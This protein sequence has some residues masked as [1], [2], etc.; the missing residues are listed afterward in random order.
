MTAT[1]TRKKPA[2]AKP[3]R[4]KVKASDE[5]IIKQY[6]GVF[7][8]IGRFVDIIRSGSED[9]REAELLLTEKKAEADAQRQVVAKLREYVDGAKH[10]LL[11]FLTPLDGSE[12][13]PLFDRMEPADEELH[14]ANADE[15][16]LEPI[17]ALK[18]SLES[19]NALVEAEVMLVGQLQDRVLKDPEDWWNSIP[20]LN[21]GS[22]AAVVDRLNDFINERSTK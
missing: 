1:A 5:E 21:F 22:S 12:I 4:S 6:E 3:Q 19:H 15:W 16:R 9:L 18:L 20:G 7:G 2:K 8:D 17:A 10:G 14:G 13:L 11:R